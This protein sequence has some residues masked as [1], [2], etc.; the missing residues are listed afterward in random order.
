MNSENPLENGDE[1]KAKKPVTRGER[2]RAGL[3]VLVFGL[4]MVLGVAWVLFSTPF[5]RAF[6]YEKECTITAVIGAKGGA[7]SYNSSSDIYI[8]SPDCSDLEFKGSQHGLRDDQVVERIRD[9]KGQTVTVDVG[10]WQLPFS[11]TVI[12]GIE[13]LDLSRE[14]KE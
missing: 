10:Y 14:S 2:I 3:F 4:P 11:T 8:Q 13:G 7:K 6:H 5:N 9:F 12:V 1:K